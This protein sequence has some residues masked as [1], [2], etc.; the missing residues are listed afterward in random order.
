[1]STEQ[2]QPVITIIGAGP[3][4]GLAIAKTFGKYG[5]K[6]AL[7]SRSTEKL[8][9]IVAELAKQ[10]VEAAAFRANVL[11]PATVAS[12][13]DAVKQRFGRID[14]LEYSPSERTLPHVSVTELTHDNAQ[15][16]LDFYAHGAIAA[17]N[18]VLS[19]MLGRGSGTILFTTGAS[20]LYPH[21]G[22]EMFG[23]VA[24]ATAWLRNWAHGL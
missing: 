3:G 2:S 19:E 20:S 18:E 7:L 23:N 9:P 24:P 16:Q 1:M 17:V 13:L 4:M 5:F 11:D 14:V 6:V 8:E 12:G 15:I 22:H 21:L 10:G